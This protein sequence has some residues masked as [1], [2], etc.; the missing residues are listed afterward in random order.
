M[1]SAAVAARAG[2]RGG[3]TP[4]PPRQIKGFADPVA[5]YEVG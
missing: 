2:E 4:L 3:L 5:L 1:V